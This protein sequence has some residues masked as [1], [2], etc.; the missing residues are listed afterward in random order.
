MEVLVLSA[1][2]AT[3]IAHVPVQQFSSPEGPLQSVV[4]LTL[5][6]SEDVIVV[7]GRN[8]LYKLSAQNLSGLAT[9]VTGPEDDNP[10]CRPLPEFCSYGR[11][12]AD[13]DNRILLQLPSPRLLACGTT[14]QGI[15]SIHD[16]RDNLAVAEPMYKNSTVNYVASRLS[17][18]AFFGTGT[19]QNVLF[20]AS[21]YDD[22]PPEYH[23]YA[24][25]ARV[26]DEP[27]TFKVGSAFVNVM[28]KYKKIK[29]RYVHG[30]SH[31][32]FA[33]FVAV[34]KKLQ[35]PMPPET[36]LARVCESDTTFRTYTEILITCANDG[37]QE[38]ANATS[39][40]YGPHAAGGVSD[41]SVLLVAFAPNNRNQGKVPVPSSH[42]ASSTWIASRKSSSRPL[43]IATT[44]SK[45]QPAGRPFSTAT[46]PTLLVKFT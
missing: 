11:T 44:A 22:R 34:Q 42:F 1:C 35:A 2:F 4:Y 43:R 27:G 5:P 8:A 39:A 31:K 14:S 37:K 16:A 23:P 7:G 20:V 36:R 26:L 15:C 25:S 30:F 10:Q 29:I 17:T 45:R 18:V 3:S 40:A 6:G 33:Y 9:F 28:D 13:N 21:T 12:K 46:R 19:N 24:V 32:G 38:Y 41:G